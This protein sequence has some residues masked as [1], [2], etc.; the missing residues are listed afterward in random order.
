MPEPG[1][2]KTMHMQKFFQAVPQS[3]ARLWRKKQQAIEF[4]AI[5]C[6]GDLQ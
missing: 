2:K 6:L 1:L 3:R 5:F 4:S